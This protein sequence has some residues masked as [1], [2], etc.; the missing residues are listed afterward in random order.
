MKIPFFVGSYAGAE[1]ESI[2]RYEMDLE[3]GSLTR[4]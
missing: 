1:E 3:N 2:Y 4:I